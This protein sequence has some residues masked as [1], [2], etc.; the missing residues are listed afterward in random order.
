[1][2]AYWPT[3]GTSG[4]ILLTSRKYYNF[5]N[6]DRRGDTVKPFDSKQSWELLLQLLGPEWQ[7]AVREGEIPQ[8]EISAAKSLL[9][10]LEGLPLA[11]QEAANLI[12]DDKI[13]GPTISKTF[14][15]FKE[16]IRT[17]PERYSSPRSSTERALDALW[18][19]SFSLLSKNAGALLGILAWLSRGL[20]ETPNLLCRCAK[21]L[22]DQIS[23][24]LFLPTMQSIL[25]GP[26]EFC[27][28]DAQN[29]DA[30]GRIP[31]GDVIDPSPQLLNAIE[32]LRSLSF[33]RV[34]GRNLS[35]HRVIQEA[36]T[37]GDLVDLQTSFDAAV[38]L[39]HY[40]FPKTEMDGSLFTQWSIFQEHI[41]HGLNL[42]R[43]FVAQTRAGALKGSVTFIEL[44]SNCAWL[45]SL[46]A[47]HLHN[48]THL[49]GISTNW[50]ITKSQ[51]MSLE[52]PSRPATTEIL[53]F[54]MTS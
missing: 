31:L 35:T 20:F 42:S 47:G 30:Y 39:V 15:I 44:M 52:L 54:M 49:I 46:S 43:K 26:L 25:D 18:D 4:A 27:K 17:L 48:I 13:G 28:Q 7:L 5:Q 51:G 36:A 45:V 8:S 23:L 33:I 19:M 29:V 3:Q 53:C 34:D 11:I 38:R 2:K 6:I 40:R 14:E 22:K 32:E 9:E 1:M 12:K 16:R 50:A 24:V 10:M 41:P 37:Y 21:V